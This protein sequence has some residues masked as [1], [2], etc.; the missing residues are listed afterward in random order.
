[1]IFNWCFFRIRIHPL[2]QRHYG[3]KLILPKSDICKQTFSFFATGSFFRLDKKISVI[4]CIKKLYLLIIAGR[5]AGFRPGLD[6][7]CTVSI[8]IRGCG[9][10]YKSYGSR[11]WTIFPKINLCTVYEF[12]MSQSESGFIKRTLTR[13]LLYAGFSTKNIPQYP[14]TYSKADIEDKFEFTKAFNSKTIPAPTYPKRYDPL[15]RPPHPSPCDPIVQYACPLPK[16]RSD[17]YLR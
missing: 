16:D 7:Y 1:M 17:G 8:R 6:S 4:C 9:S 14:D 13:G 12:L 11:K 3:I 2:L 5:W 15:M 10:L